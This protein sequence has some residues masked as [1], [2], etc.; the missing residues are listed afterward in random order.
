MSK[1]AKLNIKQMYEQE[2]Q[3]F[4]RHWRKKITPSKFH[5][6]EWEENTVSTKKL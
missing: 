6:Q 1:D 4:F 3:K 2:T 5:V